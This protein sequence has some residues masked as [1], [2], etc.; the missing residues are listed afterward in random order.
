MLIT[1]KLNYK[2]IYA[3]IYGIQFSLP[4]FYAIDLLRKV[5]KND[6]LRIKLLPMTEKDNR[7]ILLWID[8]HSGKKPTTHNRYQ[9]QV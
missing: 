5:S 2:L 1:S 9:V 6:T 4:L 3:Q 8:L 7:C